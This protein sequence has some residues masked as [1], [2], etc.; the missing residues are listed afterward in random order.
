MN[1]WKFVPHRFSGS[2]REGGWNAACR[3]CGRPHLWHHRKEFA[4]LPP[5]IRRRMES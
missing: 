3:R 1:I 2:L 4:L 5:Q